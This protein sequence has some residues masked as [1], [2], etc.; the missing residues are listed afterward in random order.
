MN[1]EIKVSLLDLGVVKQGKEIADALADI[2]TNAQKV[3]ELGFHR[4]WLAEHHNMPTVSTAATAVLI[5]HIA[6]RTSRI[7]VGAGGIM[8]PNHSPLSVTEEFGTLDTLYPGRIDLG[9][10]R[11]PGTDQPT[12]A[13]LRRG[14]LASQN[15]F[16]RDIQA[17][18]QFF[19]SDN[20]QSNVRA[21]PGEGRKVPLYILGSSTDSAYLAAELGLPYAF[22]S[23]FAPTQLFPALEIYRQNF[24]PSEVLKEPYVMAAVN[25]IAADTDEEAAHLRTSLDLMALGMV[26]GKRGKLSPPVDEMPEIFYH[27]EVQ[28][29]LGRLS[30]F[31]FDG[32]KETIRLKINEFLEQTGADELITT[33][34]IYDQEARLKSFDL[35]AEALELN[36]LV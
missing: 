11:A 24:K 21:F 16:P 20:S 31:T 35:L 7:R 3:E 6:G 30:T 32:S 25:V 18:Q 5:G 2:T 33:N 19:S 23:H 10:G 15:D 1:K 36:C 29:A 28:Q 12:A 4:I 34:Y 13:A 27:P 17:L 14:N 9:L 26:T 8:L 22:A